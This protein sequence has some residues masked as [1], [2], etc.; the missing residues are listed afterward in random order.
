MVGALGLWVGLGGLLAGVGLLILLKY[1]GVLEGASEVFAWFRELWSSFLNLAPAPLKILLFLFFVLTIAG[2]IT[3]AVLNFMY[4]C[5]SQHD[6]KTYRGGFMGG[7]VGSLQS[8]FIGYEVGEYDCIGWRQ[9]GCEDFLSEGDCGQFSNVS[10]S[11][12]CSWDGDNCLNEDSLDWAGKC[13]YMIL[14][15]SMCNLLKCQYISEDVDYD[16]WISKH[17]INATEYGRD[18]P[19]GILYPECAGLEPV[20]TLHGINIFDFRIWVVLFIIMGL[21]ALAHRFKD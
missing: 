1:S 16:N 14:N 10:G 12:L 15:Q 3:G 2:T 18:T 11:E 20:L 4:I 19:E 9:S 13:E 7:V 6:L 17:T 21:F 8:V 5:D